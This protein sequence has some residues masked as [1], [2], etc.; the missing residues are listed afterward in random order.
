[1]N[2]IERIGK[3][4]RAIRGTIADVFETRPVV[5]ILLVRPAEAED[6]WEVHSKH[7]N[8]VRLVVPGQ[9]RAIKDATELLR[10]ETGGEVVLLDDAGELLERVWVLHRDRGASEI[11]TKGWRRQRLNG[12][13]H[14]CNVPAGYLLTT[15]PNR[16][17]IELLQAL[18]G[19][20]NV[21]VGNACVNGSLMEVCGEEGIFVRCS[22]KSLAMLRTSE[23][24]FA[25]LGE[26]HWGQDWVHRASDL[27]APRTY[28]LR[29][30]RRWTFTRENLLAVLSRP[31]PWISVPLSFERSQT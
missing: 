8:S 24:W 3:W 26:T 17:L 4:P 18:I 15:T 16:E 12:W 21:R 9:K 11:Q 19:P 29:V 22:R 28:G 31:S 2:R 13:K 25:L 10:R 14:F 6:G 1:M 20:E 5:K 23:R 27:V 7:D 30:G